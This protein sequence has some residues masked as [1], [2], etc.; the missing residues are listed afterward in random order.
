MVV[1]ESWVEL[2]S[3]SEL[4]YEKNKPQKYVTYTFL[5]LNQKYTRRYGF[6]SKHC[7]ILAAKWLTDEGKQTLSAMKLIGKSPLSSSV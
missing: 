4:Q 2:F 6:S 1:Y 3:E 7:F 5:D